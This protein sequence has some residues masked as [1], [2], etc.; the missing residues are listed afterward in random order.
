[1]GLPAI[2]GSVVIIT[3]VSVFSVYKI[4]I[5]K[6]IPELSPSP[7]PIVKSSFAPKILFSPQP[8]LSPQSPP[9][10]TF[11]PVIKP[12]PAAQ[13]SGNSVISGTIY[14][15]GTAPSGTSIVIVQRPHGSNNSSQAVV[16]GITA[17]TGST[18]S[19]SGAQKGV[20]YDL[21]AVLKGQSGGQNI[22]YAQSLTYNLTAPTSGFMMTVNAGYIMSAPTGTITVT[23]N[24][25]YSN[26]TWYGTVNFPLVNNTLMYWLQV[27]ST[28]GGTDIANIPKN[29]QSQDVTINDSTAYYAQ[30]AVSPVSNPT[31]Y[32]Y[33][34]F[35]APAQIRCP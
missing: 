35:S 4:F 25:H 2:I 21:A 8:S 16:S 31:Q 18:W 24:T 13:T 20:E 28:S 32:Q 10:S 9:S 22:D 17:Q 27:G 29:A 34:A 23:C 11:Y 6:A 12:S 19:W 5:E 1:M 7:S 30:Y 14:L 26:N 3:G 15:N 33:S